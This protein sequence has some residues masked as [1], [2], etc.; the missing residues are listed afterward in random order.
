M[1]ANLSASTRFVFPMLISPSQ[2]GQRRV[3]M[4]LLAAM[5]KRS[6]V[7]ALD[8]HYRISFSS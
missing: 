4:D 1:S 3:K 5:V 8:V 6:D 2:D 7:L